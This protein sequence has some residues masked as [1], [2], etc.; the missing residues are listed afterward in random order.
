MKE[1][2]VSVTGLMVC[3]MPEL[4]WIDTWELGDRG[5]SGGGITK[6][7]SGRLEGE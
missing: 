1:T 4:L 2:S 7:K 3:G 5:C 6:E